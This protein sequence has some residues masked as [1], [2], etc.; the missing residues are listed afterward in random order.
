MNQSLRVWV[1]R[2]VFAVL[3]AAPV[4]VV[5]SRHQR[6]DDRLL[7]PGPTSDGHHQIE[8]RCGEC[9][10]RL[11]GVSA[12][13]CLRCHGES[14]AARQD[15]HAVARFDDPGRA[16]QLALVDAR[17]CLTCHREHRP[18][19][20]LRGSLTVAT[21]F[22]VAC[23]GAV[24]QERASH[25]RFGAGTCANAGC[26]NYHDNRTLYRDF[27]VKH[28]NEPDLRAEPR[29]AVLDTAAGSR[30][31]ARAITQPIAVIPP[32]VR[33]ERDLTVATAEWHGSAHARASVACA[34][35]HRPDGSPWRWS[36]GDAVCAA[37][38]A[39]EGA[40]FRAGKH[41]MR[42]AV[43]LG[44]MT[45]LLARARMRAD[46][47]A[48]TLGCNSCHAA[49]TFDRTSAAVGACQGCHADD[50]TLAFQRSPHFAAWQRELSGRGPP[51]SGVSCATCHLPRQT[52]R[53][54]VLVVQ[55][56]QNGNL[57]P[58]DRMGREVCLSCH[59]LRFSLEAL[60]DAALVARNFAGR[61]APA[62]IGIELVE[63]GTDHVEGPR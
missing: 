17:S 62:A 36:V 48:R 56:N 8:S 33:D 29:V 28:S 39:N 13:A 52:V 51:G 38:H 34:G 5:A 41:G 26:H 18:E 10:V 49:H 35:C 45:P 50:H 22:C 44:P 59:G 24:A 55:H 9:H 63:K 15:S 20:R 47:G 19:A 25:A 14:L 6:G 58:A 1:R 2:A 16:S 12:Q 46:A 61:P 30:D 32:D 40:G 23:H 21:T 31:H 37:C 60:A 4:A 54:G 53:S 43:G 57:R 3:F 42:S 27:L 11:S 7:L